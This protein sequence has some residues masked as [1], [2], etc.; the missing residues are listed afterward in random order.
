MSTTNSMAYMGAEEFMDTFL[1]M[2]ANDEA[3]KLLKD[4]FPTDPNMNPYL[5]EAMESAEQLLMSM[6]IFKLIRQGEKMLERLFEIAGA[7]LTALLALSK[8]GYDKLKNHAM[9]GRR[10]KA[11][12][13]FLS[14]V[15]D[16]AIEKCKLFMAW[17]QGLVSARSAGNEAGNLAGA[18]V[19]I[20]NNVMEH[21]RSKMMMGKGMAENMIHSL[22]FKVMTKSFKQTDENILKKILGRDNVSDLDIADVN[23]IANFAYTVDSNGDFT[24]L[25]E[26]IQTLLHGYGYEKKKTATPTV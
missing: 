20:R 14:G 25:S 7:I 3:K 11:L 16:D 22:M 18:T 9:K 13:N 6:G 12:S 1:M 17:I 15:L 21:D 24:G 10:F 23:K 8:K 26:Q 4:Y 19:D 5:K 2:W